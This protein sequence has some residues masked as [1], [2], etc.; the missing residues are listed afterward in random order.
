MEGGDFR[1]SNI[2]ERVVQMTFDNK[3]FETGVK[4]TMTSLDALNKSLKLEGATKGL[5]DVSAAAG[6]FSL[7]GIGA[8]VD[9]IASKF[10]SLG[11]IGVAALA[12]ITSQAVIA[13]ERMLKSLTLD[14]LKN[15]LDVYETKINAIQ[16]I[17]ANTASEG[18]KLPQVT[19]ALQEL[20][21]YANLTV[22]S[23]GDMAK[24]IGTFTAAGVDLKTSVASI[25][26]IANLA[27]LSG[28]SAEQAS[29]AMYQ[30]SQAIAAGSV[31]LQD[32]NSVVNAGMGGKVFQTALENTA[33]AMGIHIDT[34]LKKAGSF[35]QSL[36]EGW[37][38]SDVLTKTLAQFTGDLSAAQLKAMGFTD[39]EAQAIL[40]MGQNAVKSATDIRTV[41]QLQ[42]ALKEEVATAWASV[43]ETLIGNITDATKLLSN[44][45]NVLENAFTKPVYA[46]N[47][48]LQEWAKFGGRDAAIKSIANSFE[49]LQK[50]LQPIKDAFHE[51]FPPKTGE[52]LAGMTKALEA[53]TEKLKIGTD[54]ADKLK[55]TFAGVFAIL[56]IGWDIV[57]AGAKFLAR[58][59]GAVTQGSGGFLDVTAKIGDFLVALKAAI[60]Q[61]HGIELFFDRLG[62]FIE[63]VLRLVGL[64][65]HALSH[66]FDKFD[67]TKAAAGVEH[68]LSKL[69][70]LTRMG[71]II[72]AV[73]G[74]VISGF[75]NVWHVFEPIAQKI[76]DFFKKFTFWVENAFT[77]VNYQ[78]I[79][80]TINTGLFAGLVVL[81][82]KF[83]DK[84]K[85]HND[86]SK[87]LFDGIKEAIEGLTN[88]LKTM[89]TT[90]RAATLL[91]IA[92]AVAAL[93]VSAVALSKIDSAGLTRALTAM[94][95]MFAQLMASLAIIEKIPSNKGFAKLAVISGAM[96]LLAIAIDLLTVAVTKLSRIDMK[97][98]ANGIQAVGILMGELVVTMRLM[99][100]K[101]LMI[102]SGLGII[103]LAAAIN[104]LVSAVKDLS[105]MNW[106]QISKGLAG[107]AGLLVSLGL[108]TKF[109]EA[110]KTGVLAGA[111]I[112][113][114]AAGIK[115]LA[116]A[117]KDISGLSWESI[118]KGIATLAASLAI[119]AIALDVIPPTAVLGAAGILVVAL[120]LGM[121]AK[122]LQALGSMSWGSIGKGLT[123]M[124]GA[125]TIIS[126]AVS[127]IPP[128]A[129]LGAAAIWIVAQVLGKVA[130]VLAQMAKM[131][132]GAI[133]K[134]MVTLAA[135][136]GIIVIAVNLMT[137]ALGGA[138][139]L[140]VVAGALAILTPIL[141]TLG[142]MS[143][144]SIVKGLVA[145]AG[146]FA[147][148]G[149]AGLLLGPVVP[150]LIGLGAAIVLLG[151]GMLAAGAG[152]LLFSAGLTAL[153][154]AGAAGVTAIVAI[155]SGLIGLLPMV[156]KE[157]GE[158]LIVFAEVI[159]KAGP[160]I[161]DAITTVL[162]ALMN[163]IIKLT[164]KIVQTLGVLLD[165]FIKLMIT[166]IPKL[167]D[168]GW[169]ILLAFL[170]G[171]GDHI[172]AVVTKATD[173]VVNFINGIANNLPRLL[174]A[175]ANLV[176]KLIG[177][178][179][180]TI[181]NNGKAMGDAAWKLVSGIIDGIVSSTGELASKAWDAAVNLV[182]GMWDKAMEWLGINSPSKKFMETG[183]WSVIG[184]A[185]G[186]VKN[187]GIAEDGATTVAKNTVDAMSNSL[188][189]L[190]DKIGPDMNIS[191]TITPVVDMS[192]VQDGAGQISRVLSG[193][194]PIN[195]SATRSN[196][197]DASVSGL[198][199]Q[200]GSDSQTSQTGDVIFN[201]TNNSPKP[202][203]NAEIYRQTNNQLSVART[204][205]APAK[206]GV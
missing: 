19:A 94:S 170:T 144:G 48:L 189:T 126:L 157:I 115:I 134:S 114:L 98:L 166:Y 99:P 64:L 4:E 54:T 88:T 169:K 120:S 95:V 164:P 6:R 187:S 154:V 101:G 56:G 21:K 199:R 112:V 68:I 61:G 12:N 183:K 173:I 66:V 10:K 47:T 108:F 67:P 92:L 142:N 197:N 63:P 49:A 5:A 18:T 146:V 202:L 86:L 119:M 167:I 171:I 62:N 121:I 163:A 139:A 43:W 20:N 80:G 96:I 153:S 13:G 174:Q 198:N 160:A 129:P 147:V 123:A 111:G 168:M 124:L 149:V 38:T 195:L 100:A 73:W 23:F 133:L 193:T 52:Q 65:A 78:D 137:G 175:G 83:Y 159:A 152:L 106:E 77:G 51:I 69:E 41:T 46:L 151:V 93:T 85:S 191:P 145:L 203:N 177:G 109:A 30:L 162:L 113:L 201:Q 176:I 33:R 97:A 190:A 179:G 87:G 40:V 3:Q 196:A 141:I 36:Q 25:K 71:D 2:D 50:I 7:S 70:P 131:S 75:G 165:A 76:A 57:K 143:W 192:Q 135:S 194:V 132:W 45:H 107:V 90:L 59:F 14:N 42:A 11:T 180:D 200:N 110:G 178:I 185:T 28:S 35:R 89:Q 34:I 130:D 24:N 105:A 158:A 150:I 82:K 27:A 22:F 44:V 15:G 140:L 91:E 26:G 1:M 117:M 127:L 188:S 148:I 60:E 58:M 125:I 103:A 32:W 9:L 17:L 102:S 29:T 84:F 161:T 205:L 55:R 122:A 182:K 128:T 138:A 181:K 16:T 184:L 37:L 72:A 186:L 155:V 79:L 81:I 136:L 116:S 104:I 31:H 53:F 39:K 8:G 74:S 206:G 156:A 118:A 172:G 204:K